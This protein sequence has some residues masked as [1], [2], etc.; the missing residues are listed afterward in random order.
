MS[1]PVL[2][3]FYGLIVRMYWEKD[4]RHSLPHIHVK[5]AEFEVVLT[6]E[7]EVLEGD[8]PP[9]KMKLIQAWIELHREELKINWEL[10][11][12]NQDTFR[13]EPLR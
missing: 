6:L 12:N 7:G 9:P 3:M 11:S 1:M 10:A 5:H 4:G 2:S 13:I 8:L